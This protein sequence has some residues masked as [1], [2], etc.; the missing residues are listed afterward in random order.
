MSNI[1]KLLRSYYYNY[2]YNRKLNQIKIKKNQIIILATI[3]KSGT[4]YFKFLLSNYINLLNNK[5]NSKPLSPKGVND[6]F[7]NI[8]HKAY[9][10]KDS[11]I[12][13]PLNKT[14]ETIGYYDMPRTHVQYDK[15]MRG[16]KILHL[17]RNPL[18]Y[19]VSMYY[20]KYV[21][22]PL[23]KNI[24]NSP[25]E[26]F[27][28]EFD[29]YIYPYLSYK[30]ESFSKKNNILRISYED[31]VM[32]TEIVFNIILKWLGVEVDLQLVQKAIFNSSKNTLR[33]FEKKEPIHIGRT[34]LKGSFLRSGKVG[35]WKKY[36]TNVQIKNV[37][38]KL[39]RFNLSLDE[40]IIS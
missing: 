27:E 34:N 23:F 32:N 26:V 11:K 9:V 10:A 25:Y 30:K 16:S 28:N 31:F 21:H 24:L 2:L 29:K 1:N 22:N 39:A 36:F 18:D 17:Y 15:R 13:K 14:M 40:F 20:Y 4:H 6:Y 8:W 12:I 19:C 3:A 5:K 33:R 37:N 7:P 35:E 38:K